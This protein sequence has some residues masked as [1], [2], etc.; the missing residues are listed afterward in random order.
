M[1][2]IPHKIM[3]GREANREYNQQLQLP[4]DYLCIFEECGGILR[5]TIA[6][7]AMQ[8]VKLYVPFICLFICCLYLGIVCT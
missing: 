3:T 7:A 4:D 2:N 8:V 1:N 6:V 5:A